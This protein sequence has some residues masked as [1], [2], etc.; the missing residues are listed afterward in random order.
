[1][2]NLRQ[3]ICVFL[4]HVDHGKSS[5]IEKI[6]GSSITSKE[7]GGITQTIKAY[8][9]DNKRIN[10]V[11]GEL[12]KKLKIQLNIPGILFI[13]SPGHASFT[14]LRKRGGNI[15]DIAVLV[16]D[17]H[18]GIMQQ[19]LES[20]EILKSYKT[21]FVIALNKIDLIHGWRELNGNLIE[22]IEGQN[23]TAKYDLEEKLY[24]LVEKL[25]NHGINADRYDRIDD[26]T[27]KV[28]IIPL[29]AK[30]QYGISELLMVITGLAQKYLEGSL[31]KKDEGRAVIL[32]I[33]E[34][35][36]LG[37]IAEVI[38]Y[39]GSLKNN[40]EIVVG[41][42]DGVFSTK[43]RGL[44]VEGKSIKEVCAA[45][46]VRL[47]SPDIEKS[48]PGMPIRVVKG[49]V[50]K[51]KLEIKKE[52]DYSK[53]ELDEKGIV[54][55]ADSLGSLEALVHLLKSKGVLIRKIGIGEINKKDILEAKSDEL[56]SVIIG[57]NLK[58]VKS[59]EVKII[60]ADVIYKLIDIYEEWKHKKENEINGKALNKLPML[61]KI[62]IMRGFIFRQ[63]NPAVVGTEVLLGKLWI[64]SKVM[65][66]S[67]EYISD[68]KSIQIN[69]KGECEAEKGKQVATAFTKVTVG[70][71]INE[72]E[73]LYS[74]IT[75]NEFRRFKDVKQLLSHEHIQILKEIAE[76]KRRK[77]KNW[78]V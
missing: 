20:I 26:F 53:I 65:N 35:K 42:L 43:I 78:G 30:K 66:D 23:D 61:F 4:G 24:K 52:I 70:R 49:D 68:I 59:E 31:C 69:G 10:Q 36:S 16:I 9:V 72:D 33:S 73:V 67:G 62:K 71:Q 14:S 48:S 38:L 15:A 32:E 6:R 7:A 44:F 41:S 27:K 47:F 12:L 45:N 19:T 25:F 5:I 3:P 64:D 2:V 76:I 21:P 56:S 39:E 22:K 11:A 54:A 77:N 60:T 28:A 8:L 50:E 46:C 13:D 40:D 63:S 58:D 34:D 1:M 17:V 18:E 74:E 51:V 37:K 57:F 29:S 55:K 75:E